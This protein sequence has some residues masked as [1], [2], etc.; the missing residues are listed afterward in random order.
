MGRPFALPQEPVACALVGVEIHASP[1]FGL[2][3]KLRERRCGVHMVIGAAGESG[4][5]GVL[6]LLLIDIAALFA[7][8][9]GLGSLGLALPLVL[10]LPL[11]LL[12]AVRESAWRRQGVRT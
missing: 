6:S 3:E 11:A 2:G 12:M 9:S 7:A 8:E 1:L 10:T 4:L 5:F